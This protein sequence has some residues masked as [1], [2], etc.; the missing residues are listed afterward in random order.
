MQRGFVRFSYYKTANCIAPC[1]AMHYYV[2]CSYAILQTILVRF[3]LFV[4][5]NEHPLSITI[6]ASFD[7]NHFPVW[8]PLNQF[9]HDSCPP[10][11]CLI[12]SSNFS[13]I[14]SSNFSLRSVIALLLK[15]VSL[16][17]FHSYP[18]NLNHFFFKTF[19]YNYQYPF[20][21]LYFFVYHNLYIEFSIYLKFSTI[22][23]LSHHRPDKGPRECEATTCSTYTSRFV[24]I[25]YQMI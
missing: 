3:L 21:F 20:L 6:H 22:H 9:I 13:L 4:W 18:P 2:R 1:S 23:L 14:D 16:R 12:D 5:F 24:Y 15:Q 7:K 19:F 8:Y 10:R 25:I 17:A 11:V